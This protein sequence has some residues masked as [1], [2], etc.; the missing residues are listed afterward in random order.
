MMKSLRFFSLSKENF[1]ISL[2]PKQSTISKSVGH[3]VEK[4][5]HVET[6]TLSSVE[7]IVISKKI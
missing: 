3:T 7:K 6:L 4:N 5:L 2:V 1:G